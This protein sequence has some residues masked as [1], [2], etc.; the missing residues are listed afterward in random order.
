MKEFDLT[1]EKWREYEFNGT[2][3]RIE[4]PKTLFINENGGTHHRIVDFKNVVHCVPAPGTGNCVLR[5]Q[6]K[7]SKKPVNF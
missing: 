5:W 2:I 7:N 6:S 4:K 1:C 3:Y